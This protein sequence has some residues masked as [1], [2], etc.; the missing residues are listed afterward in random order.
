MT[1]IRPLFILVLLLSGAAFAQ[2]FNQTQPHDCNYGTYPR[3]FAQ[4]GCAAIP[5][6][7]SSHYGTYAFIGLSDYFTITITGEIPMTV[8]KATLQSLT[9]PTSGQYGKFSFAFEAGSHAG[10]VSGEWSTVQRIGC[11]RGGCQ[12]WYAPVIV[13]SVVNL[14]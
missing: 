7:G 14:E 2:T 12:T 11:S 8:G 5:I 9:Q 1:G 4:F 6:L 13:N 10:T 3:T